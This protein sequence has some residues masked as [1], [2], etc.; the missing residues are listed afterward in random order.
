MANS[1]EIAEIVVRGQ[2]FRD[3]TSVEVSRSMDDFTATYFSLGIAESSETAGGWPAL[4]LKPGDPCVINLAGKKATDGFINVRQAAYNA[5]AHGVTVA[6][7]SKLGDIVDSSVVAKNGEFKNY[8][9]EQIVRSVLN[10]FGIKLK[11][12]AQPE[13]GGK[14]PTVNIQFGETVHQ[15]VERLTRMVNLHLMDDEDGNLVATKAQGGSVA[16]LVEGKNI[17]AANATL[18]D[19]NVFSP[20]VGVQQQTGNDKVW[21]DEARNSS[22]TV[23][24][25]SVQRYRPN[26]FLTEEPGDKDAMKRR[27]QREVDAQIGD[28]LIGTIVVQGWLQDNRTLW[29][30][31]V[32][33]LIVVKSPMLFPGKNGSQL[34]GVKAVSCGQDESGTISTI[35]ICLPQALGAT[36]NPMPDTSSSNPFTPQPSAVTFET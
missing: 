8:N 18:S 5:R 16:E 12:E 1:E 2:K 15:L 32:G 29:L 36:A 24:N 22:A 27:V 28:S 21:G 35:S 17:K 19:H 13:G 10:P 9:Y 26:K 31:R 14:L 23:E 6:G 30:N 20:N 4:K 7:R 11:L 25:P 33:K 34:V 3:W